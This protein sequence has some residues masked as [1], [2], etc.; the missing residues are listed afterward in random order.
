MYKTNKG[1]LVQ[2]CLDTWT[3]PFSDDAS[4]IARDEARYQNA[5]ANQ[6]EF[7]DAEIQEIVGKLW[8]GELT[9]KDIFS[10]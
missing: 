9:R 8:N 1:N 5:L 7:T 4:C 2:Y 10:E 6:S 3:A